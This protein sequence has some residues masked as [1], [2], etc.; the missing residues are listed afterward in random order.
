M[1][2]VVAL[3]EEDWAVT[4]PHH[5]DQAVGDRM[6]QFADSIWGS[7]Y[8]DKL[9]RLTERHPHHIVE[10]YD[11]HGEAL[12]RHCPCLAAVRV[13]PDEGGRGTSRE[14]SCPEGVARDGNKAR[15]YRK[16]ERLTCYRA[17]VR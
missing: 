4:T 6:H 13:D 17:R 9:V 10:T 16:R 14:R 2:V 12:Q 15:G 1:A 5:Q 11:V 3:R 7:A 8:G